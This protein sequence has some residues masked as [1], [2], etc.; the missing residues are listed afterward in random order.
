M[1]PV[2]LKV[3]TCIERGDWIFSELQHLFLSNLKNQKNVGEEIHI[4]LMAYEGI[5]LPLKSSG[6]LL[7][8]SS[9]SSDEDFMKTSKLIEQVGRGDE[10]TRSEARA[11]D[12]SFALFQEQY[13][14]AAN[15]FQTV[16]SGVF[17][18]RDSNFSGS[19]NPRAW[20]I[21]FLG[22]R[23][24]DLSEDKRA[25]S[26][27]HEMAH[28]ELFLINLLDRLARKE[29]DSS[30]MFAPLQG[31]PRPPIKRLHSFWALF[32]MLQFARKYDLER[33]E[34]SLKFKQNASSFLEHEL[35]DYGKKL[36]HSVEKCLE[37]QF[38]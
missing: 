5:R 19:S 9:F 26:F 35:T 32:R 10:F 21:C 16:I 22:D 31:K 20:G 28:Q 4:P 37:L 11:F 30:L 2:Q 15:L 27:V 3:L 23:F 24:F 18:V 25:T 7:A 6:V 14:Q 17:R 8:K 12:Q 13:S 1:N 29:A 34:I 36:I 38:A 33:E